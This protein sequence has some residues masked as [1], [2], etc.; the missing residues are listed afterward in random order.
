M[1]CFDLI[2]KIKIVLII[3]ITRV[4]VIIENIFFDFI[5]NSSNKNCFEYFKL[6]IYS[7]IIV[8]FK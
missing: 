3:E 2:V 4:I 5:S 8:Q 1:F 6:I 7:L